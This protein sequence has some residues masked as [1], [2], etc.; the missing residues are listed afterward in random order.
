MSASNLHTRKFF[1]NTRTSVRRDNRFT[2]DIIDQT[3]HTHAMRGYSVFL[4]AINFKHHVYAINENNN[5][6]VVANTVDG[7][8]TTTYTLDP[9]NYNDSELVLALEALLP[10]TDVTIDT[11]TG[12]LIIDFTASAYV[13]STDVNPAS[14]LAPLLGYVT[15][16]NS[17]FASTIAVGQEHVNIHGPESIDVLID[18][19]INSFNSTRFG[20]KLAEI[21]ID[22]TFNDQV[23]AIANA[24]FVN[25][26]TEIFT[27]CPVDGLLPDSITFALVDNWGY[28]YIPPPNTDIRF[29]V[30]ITPYYEDIYRVPHYQ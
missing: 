3:S 12:I 8:S 17:G 14:T 19:P 29:E 13:V 30:W 23:E 16:D 10:A 5:T 11:V 24:R 4:K 15:T 28:N 20:Y 25:W 26:A 2:F 21:P 22:Y 7:L 27:P 18:L 9:G 1:F 6:L